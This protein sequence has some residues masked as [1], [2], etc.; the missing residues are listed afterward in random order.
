MAPEE[1][2]RIGLGGSDLASKHLDYIHFNNLYALPVQHQ[3]L[4]GLVDDIMK[5]LGNVRFRLLS[6]HDKQLVIKRGNSLRHSNEI[7]DKYK[8]CIEKIN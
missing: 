5:A 1:Y 8:C 4:R 2:T 6:Q 7:H 3:L